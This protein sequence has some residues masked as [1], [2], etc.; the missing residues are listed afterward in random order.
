[1]AIHSP[2]EISCISFLSTGTPVESMTY[3]S[4]YLVSQSVFRR[5]YFSL[6]KES[7]MFRIVCC[8]MFNPTLVLPVRTPPGSL[9]TGSAK[10]FMRYDFNGCLMCIY[11]RTNFDLVECIT[12]ERKKM[13]RTNQN[14]R[15]RLNVEQN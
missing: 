1:M 10:T 2:G 14:R 6:T 4:V 9:S 5:K 7:E 8:Q 3:L 13:Y 12:Y 15:Y 11:T